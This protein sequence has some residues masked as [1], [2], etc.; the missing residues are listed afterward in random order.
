M[1]WQEI[2]LCVDKVYRCYDRIW[3]DVWLT[4]KPRY[5]YSLLVGI[6]KELNHFVFIL[7]A[8]VPTTRTQNKKYT[9][10]QGSW[11]ITVHLTFQ[12]FVNDPL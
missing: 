2:V 11:S 12:P 1:C 3:Q 10:V 4:T 8:I 7:V 9:Q 5:M 6:I